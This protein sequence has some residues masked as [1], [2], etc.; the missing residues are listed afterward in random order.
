VRHR[1][2]ANWKTLPEKR[3][4]RLSPRLRPPRDVLRRVGGDFRMRAK[5][6]VLVNAAEPLPN[7]TLLI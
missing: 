1:C 5:T 7:L 2:A 4:R 3:Q 6:V